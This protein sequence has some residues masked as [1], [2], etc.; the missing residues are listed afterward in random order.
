MMKSGLS[1]N[2]DELR[3]RTA[4]AFARLGLVPGSSL[5]ALL[6]VVA[7]VLVATYYVTSL[8]AGTYALADFVSAPKQSGPWFRVILVFSIASVTTVLLTLGGSAVVDTVQTGTIIGGAPFSIVI[9]LM[10]VNTIRRLLKRD[11]VIRA[12]EKIIND[13]DPSVKL[14]DVQ[15]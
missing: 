2:A 15:S 10:I 12:L 1:R 3:Q 13:P 6:M 4:A 7:T 9:L 8:D 5:D 14:E 11:S